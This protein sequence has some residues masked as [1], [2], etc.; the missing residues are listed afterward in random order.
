MPKALITLTTD[1]GTTEV[2]RLGTAAHEY[3]IL[4]VA[5]EQSAYLAARDFELL[6]GNLTMLVN[7]GR[8][9]IHFK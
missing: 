6:L 5:A 4:G 2:V 8:V 1:F 9:S 7:T 3:Q